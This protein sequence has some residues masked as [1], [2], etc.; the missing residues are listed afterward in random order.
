[1]HFNIYYLCFWCNIF[2]YKFIEF[3]FFITAVFTNRLLT[4]LKI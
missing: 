1:M 4:F 2:N 3:N